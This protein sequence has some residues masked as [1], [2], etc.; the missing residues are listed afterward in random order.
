[1]QREIET[2]ISGKKMESICMTA[3]PLFMI[4]YLRLF[5]PGFLDPMYHNF[6]GIM[7]MTIALV[8]YMAAFFWGRK[9][10]NIKL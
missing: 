8:T 10:M 1:M 6:I 7:V 2:L 3:I 5:S 9:I 4:V